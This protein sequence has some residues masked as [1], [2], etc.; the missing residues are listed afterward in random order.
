MKR[1]LISGNYDLQKN[2]E[3]E[4]PDKKEEHEF[5]EA[6]L[7][8]LGGSIAFVRGGRIYEENAG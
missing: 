2:P 8:R 1:K 3:S 6:A 4:L 5:E 7:K